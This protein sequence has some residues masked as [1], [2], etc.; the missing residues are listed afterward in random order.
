FKAIFKEVESFNPKPGV[1]YHELA[2]RFDARKLYFDAEEYFKKAIALQPKLAWPQNGL[3]LLY[4]RLGREEEARE[5]LEKAFEAD[6]FN[7]RVSNTLKVLDHLDKYTTLKT[8]H[9]HLRY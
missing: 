2:E 3:G 9:F 7:V 4:M 5:L 1:F 8:E 6:N